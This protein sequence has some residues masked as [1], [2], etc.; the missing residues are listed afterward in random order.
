VYKVAAENG[1]VN[2]YQNG[3]LKYSSAAAPTFP[4]LTD[5]SLQEL[6]TAVQNAVIRH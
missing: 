2:Y 6:N 5:S 3:T 4:L 1:R